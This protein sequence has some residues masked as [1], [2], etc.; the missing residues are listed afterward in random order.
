MCELRR[1][2][3]AAVETRRQRSLP[4]QRVRP[5]LQNERHQPTARQAKEENGE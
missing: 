4:L 2:I 5:L 1:D 3:D